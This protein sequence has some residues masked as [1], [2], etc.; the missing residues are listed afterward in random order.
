L[1]GTL[2]IFVH[3]YRWRE[4]PIY[5]AVCWCIPVPHT[6]LQTGTEV[7]S[8]TYAKRLFVRP[9]PRLQWNVCW[10]WEIQVPFY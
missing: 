3:M 7:T 4:D 5:T 9:R 1:K 8:T 10:T 6:I 2:Y